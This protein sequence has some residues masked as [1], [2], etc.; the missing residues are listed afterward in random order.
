MSSSALREMHVKRK[1]RVLVVD[2]SASMR[3]LLEQIINDEPGMESVGSAP[4]PYIAREMIK[5]LNPDAI[6][7]DVEMPRMNGL[8]FLEKLMR[9]RPMPV[10]MISSLTS[11]ESGETMQALELGAMDFVLKQNSASPQGLRAMA[12]EITMKLRDMV[13]A[14]PKFQLSLK[15]RTAISA[16]P[17]IRDVNNV[18]MNPSLAARKIIF[19]GSST[20]G[21]EAVRNFLS[22]MP[23][24]SPAILIAQH[25]PE[26]FTGPFARRL[27]ATSRMTVKEAVHNERIMPG[28]VYVAPGHSHLRIVKS[29]GI[30]HTHLSDSEPVNRHR[31]SVDVL[32]ESAARHAGKNAIGVMLTGMGKDGAAGMLKMK[33]A[34]AYNLAQDEASCVVFGMPKAAIE[35]G[36]THEVRPL[37]KLPERVLAQLAQ[38]QK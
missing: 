22:V 33:E 16:T 19:I 26:H 20:G 37:S 12:A 27:N 29:G 32:F 17:E 38:S 2:D 13:E 30:Y 21:T 36:A 9:L 6:T 35:L 5:A 7:L 24:G 14:Q 18:S 10:L 11:A 8:D 23:P 15:A 25:M 3:K 4:D 28:H 34:G 31:P 1:I